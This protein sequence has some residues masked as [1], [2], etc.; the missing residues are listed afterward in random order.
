MHLKKCSISSFKGG[1]FTGVWNE[2]LT[3]SVVQ[4]ERIINYI[5]P[6][7]GIIDSNPIYLEVST[8][9]NAKCYYYFK[10][11]GSTGFSYFQLFKLTGESYH[12]TSTELKDNNYE[13]SIKC[14][15]L[16]GNTETRNYFVSVKTNGK[17]V[18][19]SEPAKQVVEEPKIEDAAEEKP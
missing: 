13:M 1:L 16:S 10:L 14:S 11:S 17:I 2:Y 19:R 15:D 12:Y 3:G 4:G 9:K 18:Y 6:E 5:R 8:L 7:G